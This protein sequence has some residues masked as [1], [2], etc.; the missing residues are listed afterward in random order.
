MYA[1]RA[2]AS[3]TW[4]TRRAQRTT[5]VGTERGFGIDREDGALEM[6]AMD[7]FGAPSRAER[8]EDLMGSAV[9]EGVWRLL[10]V[11]ASGS[12]PGAL[13]NDGFDPYYLLS[14]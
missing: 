11:P 6:E 9:G 5:F 2:W 1:L 7:T 13:P 10:D 8:V 3:R 4:P 12:E 14:G